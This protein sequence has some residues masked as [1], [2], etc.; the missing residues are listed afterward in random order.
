MLLLSRIDHRERKSAAVLS[1]R[2]VP[3]ILKIS[4]A[5]L[6]SICSVRGTTRALVAA[7]YNAAPEEPKCTRRVLTEKPKLN[8]EHEVYSINVSFSRSRAF[9]LADRNSGRRKT[10][11]GDDRVGLNNPKRLCRYFDELETW[12]EQP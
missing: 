2:C 10:Q 5:R 1:R 6:C 12:H 3:K 8:Y 9:D 4:L 11:F 7:R